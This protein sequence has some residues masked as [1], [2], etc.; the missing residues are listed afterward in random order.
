MLLEGHQLGHYRIVRQIGSGGMGTIFLAEDTH[1]PRQVAV[2]VVRTGDDM[3]PAQRMLRNFQREMRAIVQLD[4]PHILPVFDFGQENIAEAIYAYLVMLYRPEGSFVEWLRQPTNTSH[5][6]LADAAQ[7]LTQAAQALYHAHAH[8]IVHQDVKPS[9][10]LVRTDPARP[11]ALPELLLADFGIARFSGAT[12]TQSQSHHVLG[13][14]MFMSPEQWDG[15]PGPASDQYALAIMAFWL[16]TGH[17]PFQGT[18]GQ[19]MRQHYM[20]QPPAPSHFNFRLNATID[21]VMLRALAKEPTQRFP[22]I[23][24]FA[25][26][27]SQAVCE[28]DDLQHVLITAHVPDDMTSASRSDAH[29]TGSVPSEE[30]KPT[31]S[32]APHASSPTDQLAHKRASA[33]AVSLDEP[34]PPATQHHVGDNVRTILLEQNELPNLGNDDTTFIMPDR[35]GSANNGV[36]RTP[37]QMAIPLHSL[38]PVPPTQALSTVSRDQQY[39]KSWWYSSWQKSLILALL[40]LIILVGSGVL[41]YRSLATSTNGNAHARLNI[42]AQMTHTLSGTITVTIVTTATHAPGQNPTSTNGTTPVP[43]STPVSGTGAQTTAMP[44]TISGGS[45]QP[46]AI[47][48]PTASSGLSLQPTPTP[49]PVP[50]TPTPTPV[51]GCTISSWTSNLRD[52]SNGGTVFAVTNYCSRTVWL[53]FT[54]APAYTTDLQICFGSSHCTGWNN[55]PSSNVG[56][57]IEFD[58]GVSVGAGFTINAR[59]HGG[60]TCPSAYTVHGEAKY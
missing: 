21:A 2:K 43:G 52:Q 48:T 35:S 44:T 11:N 34:T 22:D 47:P 45:S 32:T 36:E 38:P 18:I 53:R 40:A 8:G 4:H 31:L 6:S 13:T 28:P 41:L 55:A 56:V 14:P 9:N 49:T 29:L 12:T 7:L 5:L 33:S 46:T 10:F 15:K 59:C 54:Q 26:A 3:Q 17:F 27:F 16:L 25:S 19:I 39:T 37:V 23:L 58:S 30:E 50:P 1:M 24:A 42:T 60:A 51:P 20:T 57:F